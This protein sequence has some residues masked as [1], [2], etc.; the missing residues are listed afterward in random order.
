MIQFP[1]SHIKTR[2]NRNG[3]NFPKVM[4]EDDSHFFYS[5][6]GVVQ[7]EREL[8][9]SY[10]THASLDWTWNSIEFDDN[11]E[12]F[13]IIMIDK[14]GDVRPQK[15][16]FKEVMEICLD[17]EITE[18]YHINMNSEH[19]GFCVLYEPDD[20]GQKILEK[21]F[22]IYSFL[23]EWLHSGYLTNIA[24]YYLAKQIL[25]KAQLKVAA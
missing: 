3:A 22:T 14:N 10:Y 23:A 19:L 16:L 5:A 7:L 17:L 18:Y 2:F 25:L 1:K 9:L 21:K 8:G 11:M 4:G 15:I 24:S 6:S 13:I 12:C 20:Y